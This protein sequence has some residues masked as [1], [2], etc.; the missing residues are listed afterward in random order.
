VACDAANLSRSSELLKD[1]M[2]FGG[3]ESLVMMSHLDSIK[4]SVDEHAVVVV[5]KTSRLVF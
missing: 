2:A 4:N 1:I 3:Y 5:D